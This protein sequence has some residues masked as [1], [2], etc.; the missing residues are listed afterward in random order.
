MVPME[1]KHL[2]FVVYKNIFVWN[3]YNDLLYFQLE[4]LHSKED[5][6]SVLRDLAEDGDSES[7]PKGQSSKGQSP[8]KGQ[9]S[10][11]DLDP[12]TIIRIAQIL[13]KLNAKG[14]STMQTSSE[15]HGTN[16]ASSTALVCVSFDYSAIF[17][18]KKK[19]LILLLSSM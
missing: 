19:Q 8:P 10:Y 5:L 2:T 12:G 14:G 6:S 4:Q 16:F 3:T 13:R 7:L 1:I 11:I 9:D 17:S 15:T 18:L